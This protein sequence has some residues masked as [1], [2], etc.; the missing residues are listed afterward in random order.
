MAEHCI[1]CA[2]LGPNARVGLLRGVCKLLRGAGGL[3]TQFLATL[4]LHVKLNR[5]LL[6]PPLL[7]LIKDLLLRH[8]DA[9][10]TVGDYRQRG[11][12][13]D[14]HKDLR[15]LEGEQTDEHHTESD[16]V[17][18]PQ[19]LIQTL[20]FLQQGVEYSFLGL[21]RRPCCARS[22]GKFNEQSIEFSAGA[23]NC[24]LRGALT[25]WTTARTAAGTS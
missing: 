13:R 17:H 19:R 25:A 14:R 18:Q 1:G 12:N 16:R 22:I 24:C 15:H 21:R 6:A 4:I 3:P 5:P 8:V 7:N 9:R 11:G 20:L 23:R 2:A 10:N